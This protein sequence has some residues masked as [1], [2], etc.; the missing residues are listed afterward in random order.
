[1]RLSFSAAFV[2]LLLGA[3]SYASAQTC[4]GMSLGTNANLNGYVPFP[5]TNVWNTNIASAPLD[6]NSAAITSA[7]GFAGLHLHHDFW[8]TDGMP[9]MV[10]D[11]TVIPSVPINVI[12]YASESDIV[13][14][15]YPANAPIEGAPAD[16]SGWPDTYVGDSH[17]LVL[18]RATCFLYETYNTHR[19]NGAYSA[20]SETIW[21]MN[22]YETRPWGWTSADAAGLPIFPGL[23]R[24]DEIASGAIHH[25]IRFTMAQ[26]KND[27]NNGYFVYPASHASGIYWGVSN[28]MGM[29]IRLKASFD[30]SGF[31][32]VNQIILTAMKQYGMI[33][34]DNG[35]YFFFQGVIDPRWNDSDLNNLDA[36]SSLNFEVVQAIPEFPGYDS[37][38]APTGPL[39][40]INSFTASS[41]GI[42]SGTPVTFT[43]S[44]SGDSYDFIDMIGPI[45]AGSGSVTVYPTATQTYTLNSTNAYG[46]TT[47]T[48]LTVTMYNSSTASPTFGPTAGSYTSVQTVTLSS[49]TPGATIYFTTN[50]TTPTTSSTK[51][52]GALTVSSSETIQA[53]AVASGY[54]TS[55]VSSAAY[56]INLP[57]PDFSVAASPSTLAVTSGNSVTTTISVT[58]LNGFNS[59][60]SFNC[61]AGLPSSVSCSF[62]PPTVTPSGAAASTTLKLTASPSAASLGRDGRPLSPWAVLAGVLCCLGLKKRRLQMLLLLAVSAIGLSLLD[63]CNSMNT[64]SQSQ[65]PS[66][67]ITVTATS[68]S[69]QRSTLLT[70]TLN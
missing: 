58:P 70:L 2:L 48:P 62:T 14:A 26:T 30:I 52:T 57:Q 56:T 21:D 63:G 47:S 24:Y 43:Y 12:D 15:P 37:E 44:V 35:G 16:C 17:M 54:A 60:V 39:P 5:A 11:S 55:A 36:I 51:Y 42:V 45:T 69:L 64:I 66:S 34:A 19:C 1:M 4:A 65:S 67:T 27:A 6:P 68:G 7:S 28:V 8:S 22:N 50:N 38:T 40:A 9:Y 31:S 53:I 29:R 32:P 3:T 25:A 10:V 23:I 13:V 46:R 61:A 18:D 49:T 20:S 33:L 59:T 41:A